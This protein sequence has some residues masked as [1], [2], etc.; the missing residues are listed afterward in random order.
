MSQKSSLLEEPHDIKNAPVIP[1]T[2]QIHRLVKKIGEDG[3][4]TISFFNISFEVDPVHV[5]DYKNI[6]KCSDIEK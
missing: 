5:K 2:L 3:K 6:L 1:D 4:A